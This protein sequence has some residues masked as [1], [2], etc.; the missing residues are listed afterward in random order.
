MSFNRFTVALPALAFAVLVAP[1]A[2]GLAHLRADIDG[3]QEVPP[4]GSLGTGLAHT[5]IDVNTN[6]LHYRI[7]FSGLSGVET[8]AHIHGPAPPGDNACVLIG[9]PAGRPKDGT[10]N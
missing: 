7:T 9:L 6:T 2:H 10:W 8:N 5:L 3:A 4:T 1:P